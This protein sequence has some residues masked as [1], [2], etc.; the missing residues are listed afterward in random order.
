M[1]IINNER[2]QLGQPPNLR[3]VPQMM[4]DLI[5]TTINLWRTRCE[6]MHGGSN[7]D[8][9]VKTRRILSKQVEDLKTRGHNLGWK[10]RDHMSGA[11]DESA[12]FWVIRAWIRTAQSL[13]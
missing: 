2:S 9:I 13:F 10:G 11:P 8:N 5:T 4:T 12:Q 3:A 1:D 7:I 6:F